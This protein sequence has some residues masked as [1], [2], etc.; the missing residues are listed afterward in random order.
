MWIFLGLAA[1]VAGIFGLADWYENTYKAGI[2]AERKAKEDYQQGLSDQL[3][4]LQNEI[5]LDFFNSLSQTQADLNDAQLQLDTIDKN[6][7]SANDWLSL[8]QGMLNGEDNL[9]SDERD[10]LNNAITSAENQVTSSKNALS[11]YEQTS[12]LAVRNIFEEANEQVTSAKQ[13]IALANVAAGATGSALGAYRTEAMKVRSDLRRYVGADGYLNEATG[14]GEIGTFAQELIA[15]RTE[16]QN[17]LF[18]LDAQVQ[19]S[20]LALSQAQYALDSWDYET[21]KQAESYQNDIEGLEALKESYQLQL[22]TAKEN[23]KEYSKSAL[24]KIKDW[25]ETMTEY[26]ETGAEDALSNEEIEEQ[27][28]SWKDKYK[29][30]GSAEWD[31]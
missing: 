3:Q 7:T 8:Y 1:A 21:E 30:Y 29:N 6:I 16:I 25:K 19:A 11:Q 28:Q 23:I 15:T 12:A 18:D 9:L 20:Q 22:E 5:N 10:L 26:A 14:E 31:I 13:S 17:T 27:I 24:E 4:N 2:D